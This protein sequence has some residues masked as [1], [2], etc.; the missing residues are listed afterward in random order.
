MQTRDSSARCTA[1][2]RIP[3]LER[4]RQFHFDPGADNLSNVTVRRKCLARCPAFQA[5]ASRHARRRRRTFDQR[6][7]HGDTRPREIAQGS[8]RH[9]IALRSKEY[10]IPAFLASIDTQKQ[11]KPLPMKATRHRRAIGNR[12]EQSVGGAVQ[13]AAFALFGIDAPPFGAPGSGVGCLRHVGFLHRTHADRPCADRN[14]SQQRPPLQRTHRAQGER[15]Q[16]G[17]A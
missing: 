4:H 15:S 2:T 10:V 17:P 8:Q 14:R 1:S 9:G 13:R 5:Y 3:A 11:S 16:P 7:T 6:R 12:V